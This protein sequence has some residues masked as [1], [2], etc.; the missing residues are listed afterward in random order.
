MLVSIHRTNPSSGNGSLYTLPCTL[1]QPN[2][3]SAASCSA[4]ST[5]PDDVEIVTAIIAMANGLKMEVIAEGV[6]TDEQLAA[7]KELG[8]DKVQGRI[9]SRPL[10]EKEFVRWMHLSTVGPENSNSLIS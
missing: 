10:P 7:L 1:S 3:R 8:C 2:S 6:E 5:D 4:V 9:C